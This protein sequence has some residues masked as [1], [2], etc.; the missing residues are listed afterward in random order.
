MTFR[1]PIDDILFTLSLAAGAEAFEP[2]GIYA[3]LAGGVAQQTLTEAAK[4]AQE[5][6]LPL[7][8]KGDLAGARFMDGVVTTAPGSRAAYGGWRDGGWNAIAAEPDDGGLVSP[9]RSTPPARKLESGQHRLRAL[10]AAGQGAIEAL[11]AHATAAL[12]ARSTHG[13]GTAATD[14]DDGCRR[15]SGGLRS[16]APDDARHERGA[17]AGTA[18]MDKRSTSPTESMISPTTSFTSCSPGCPMRPPASKAFRFSSRRSFCPTRMAPSRDAT[19]CACVG[20]E[21][22]LGI[23]ASPTCT[24]A[25]R[26]EEGAVGF[27]SSAKRT[28]GS[29]ACSR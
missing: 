26:G 23:R 16:R 24:M 14:R 22:K 18:S 17:T 29:P 12:K 8:R 10:S 28:T 11:T 13:V 3:D 2:D 27:N 15:A 4:F 1:A 21:H 25:Y 7:D 20:I 5:Q 6:L 19:P 9:R